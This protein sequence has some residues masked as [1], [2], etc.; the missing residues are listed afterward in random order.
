M[1]AWYIRALH[2]ETARQF[3]SHNIAWRVKSRARAHIQSQTHMTGWVFSTSYFLQKK[4]KHQH[5]IF[6]LPYKMI[7]KF[8]IQSI[9]YALSSTYAMRMVSHLKFD[10]HLQFSRSLL[11]RLCYP[12]IWSSLQQCPV[13][14]RL[15]HSYIGHN[16]CGFDMHRPSDVSWVPA[17]FHDISN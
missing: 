11:V 10:V 5:F 1:R 16:K 7:I 17:R 14:W 8:E 3:A 2:L 6:Y 15:D 4:K 9:T 12:E 13:C